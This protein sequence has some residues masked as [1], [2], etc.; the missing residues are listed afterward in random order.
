MNTERVSSFVLPTRIVVGLGHMGAGIATSLVR[1]G[2]RVLGVDPGPV[3]TPAGV[4]RTTLP[5][6]LA[7]SQVLILSLPGT[8]QVDQLLPDLERAPA[9]V[10]VIDA[11]T[12]PPADTRRR[13]ERL[14]GHGHV[15]V[16]APVSGGPSGAAEGALTVFLGCSEG[17]LEDVL[18][19]L[20]PLAAHVNHVGEVGAGNTAK[21]MNNLLC[22]VHLSVAQALHGAAEASGVEV[23]RLLAAVNTASGRS[24]VTEVNLP[25]WVLSGSFDSGFPVGLMARDVG[26]AADMTEELGVSSPLVEAA[27]AMW[28]GLLEQ[29]G[30]KEDFNRMVTTR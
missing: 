12:C 16:D 24:A 15:L 4:A 27:R 7:A 21:L 20:E 6:A 18:E 3:P 25:R 22:G 23:E 2:H 11:S 17:H 14:A 26:L 8:E 5:E 29:V 13:S 9:P 1:A 19:V 10:L 28:D 30:P